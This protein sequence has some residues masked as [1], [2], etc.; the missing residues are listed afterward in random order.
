MILAYQKIELFEKTVFEHVTFK[1]PLKATEI[2]ENE[3]C[4]IYAMNGSSEM[5]G[6]VNT[7]SLHA[8]ESVLMKCGS[9]VNSWKITE[10]NNPYEAIAIHFYPDVIQFIFENS[11]PEYLQKPTGNGKWVF[12]TESE[13]YFLT[14]LI[15]ISL[16]L[17]K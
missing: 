11:I 9:F 17:S 10:N 4:L 1:P 13:K 8:N 5:S 16:S 14:F 7:V 3:A 2:M 15:P 12:Q 6:G